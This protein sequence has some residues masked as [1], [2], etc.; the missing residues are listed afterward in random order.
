M[1]S[2]QLPPLNEFL[3][4][5]LRQLVQTKLCQD[6]QERYDALIARLE[7]ATSVRTALNEL[8][9]FVADFNLDPKS[10]AAQELRVALVKRYTFT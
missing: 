9:R 6:S 5:D 1:Q 8:D 7:Q 2:Q 3:S 10:K 4:E